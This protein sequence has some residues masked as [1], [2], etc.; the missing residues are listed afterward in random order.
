MKGFS[1]AQHKVD[2]KSNLPIQKLTPI[3]IKE[4]KKEKVCNSSV[5]E[6]GLSHKCGSSQLFLFEEEE[7]EA[8]LIL[9]T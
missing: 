7:R 1:S 3:K 9:E 8:Q 2:S 6:I 4:K 5:M